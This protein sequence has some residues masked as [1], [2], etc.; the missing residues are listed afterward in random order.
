MHEPIRF[1]S[2]PAP[3]TC[4]L[5]LKFWYEIHTN[6]WEDQDGTSGWHTNTM[7]ALVP[8]DMGLTRGEEEE[9]RVETGGRGY[10]VYR[11]KEVM[12]A[13]WRR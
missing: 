13:K 3:L 10:D 2:I 1:G 9:E 11:G 8:T 4:A 7:Y 12:V 6:P 5:G